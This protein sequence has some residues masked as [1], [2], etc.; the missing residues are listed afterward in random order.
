[1][2]ACC[3]TGYRPEKFPF[4]LSADNQDFRHFEQ[5]LYESIFALHAS[6]CDVFYC[7]G[8]RGFDILAGETVLLLKK[9]RP[10]KLIMA[11]PFPIQSKKW[12]ESEK[13]KYNSLLNEAD[14][15]I[16]LENEYCKWAFQKRNKFMVDNSDIVLT[17]CD[18]KNG[19]TA[20]TIKYAL[21]KGRRIINLATDNPFEDEKST[22]TQTGKQLLLN[23]I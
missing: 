9:R 19:G 10:A 1:M 20:N 4:P 22:L 13:E 3:F 15:I 6:G 12:N 8:A 23:K 18:G 7:G 11:L 16:Y 14:E 21:S 17:F 5:K 2:S